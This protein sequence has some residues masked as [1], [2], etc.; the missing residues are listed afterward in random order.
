MSELVA[1]AFEPD[2]LII[3]EEPNVIGFFIGGVLPHVAVPDAPPHSRYWR[4][5]GEDYRL[6]DNDPSL[7]QSWVLQPVAA[8]LHLPVNLGTTSTR[9]PSATVVYFPLKRTDGS[10]R[11]LAVFN[12]VL[13]I[14]MN[15]GSLNHLPAVA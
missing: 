6:Q 14:L 2:A 9:I 5:N 12:R 10:R 8:V 4:T 11:H 13:T 7:Q 15:D 1:S 3:G